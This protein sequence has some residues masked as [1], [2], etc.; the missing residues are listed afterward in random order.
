M[1][2]IAYTYDADVHCPDCARSYAERQFDRNQLAGIGR[3]PYTLPDRAPPGMTLN[4]MMRRDENGVPE[5]FSDSEGNEGAVVFVTD[6]HD[7]T[8][9]GT[10]REELS[11]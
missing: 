2:I 7:F 8:H 6:E 3:A 9:C 10:C 1:R 5:Y 11:T 4:E